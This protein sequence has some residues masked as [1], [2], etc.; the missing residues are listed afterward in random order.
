M[1]SKAAIEFAQAQEQEAEK[2][3]HRIHDEK[4][5]RGEGRCEY[6]RD[7]ARVLYSSSFRR[8]QGKMQLL[9]VN[10]TKFSRNRLT[11]SLE[12]AQ[13]ARTIS[14]DLGL[15]KPVVA[16][17]CA[18]LHDIGNPPYGHHGEV[19]LHAKT[20]NIG[21]FEG[22]AQ[23]L[24]ILRLLEKKGINYSGL[25]L[26]VRTL[27]GITKYPYKKSENPK[28]FIYD[29]DYDFLMEQLDS[30]GVIGKKSIDAQIMD[31]SDEIAYAAHDLEDALSMSLISIGE[32]VHE[33]KISPDFNCV[34]V[35]IKEIVKECQKEASE[36]YLLL[37]SEEYSTVFKKELTSKIVNLLCRDIDIVQ[38]NGENVLGYKSLE[39]VALGLKKLVFKTILRKT[40]VQQYEKRGEKV[41]NGLLKVY[42][43]ESFN[44]D[45]LLLPPELR[46]L[47]GTEI[48]ERLIV[49]Y[50]S[51]MMD[52]FAAQ[53][54]IKYFGESDYS[55]LY[56]IPT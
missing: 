22:N 16:E 50:I 14:H 46:V 55:R 31:L 6:S 44:K 8:L 17:T 4:N 30:K 23:A 26:T 45:L 34:H 54:Y 36:S 15:S 11:H 19:I 41:L 25:N 21:G 33:F 56:S 13:I 40:S 42:S 12:V 20:E 9:G 32:L 7:Y 43:D 29:A 18:L 1:Y 47:K 27:W 28:K 10:H 51:G 37:T 3:S 2:L 35:N 39:K 49:D 38:E 52:A 24:R 48:R 53:E 5:D